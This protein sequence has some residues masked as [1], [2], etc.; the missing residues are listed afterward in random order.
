[1]KTPSSRPSLAMFFALVAFALV[2][3]LAGVPAYAA[4]DA[5]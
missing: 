3:L 1:M 5:A 4:D 2:A